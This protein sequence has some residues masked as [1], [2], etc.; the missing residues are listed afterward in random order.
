MATLGSLLVQNRIVGVTEIEKALQRQVIM[1]GDLATNLLELGS[2]DENTLTKYA[3]EAFGM[4]LLE[5]S[6]LES[7]DEKVVRMMPWEAVNEHKIAPIR[8][9]GNKMILAVSAPLPKDSLTDIGFLLGVEFSP[10]F[11]MEFRAAVLLNRCFGIPVPKRH[12]AVQKRLAPDAVLDL[13][14]LVPPPGRETKLMSAAGAEQKNVAQP[15]VPV[16]PD[17]V[18]TILKAAAPS[19]ASEA[20]TVS[21]SSATQAALFSSD[22]REPKTP[23]SIVSAALES[24]SPEPP[25]EDGAALPPLNLEAVKNKLLQAA[26]RDEILEV[27]MEAASSMFEY[28]LLFVIHGSEAAAHSTADK[29]GRIR[30]TSHPAVPLDMGGMFQTA[31]TTGS[32]YLGAPGK[33]SEDALILQEMGREHPKNCAILPVSLRG[34][35]ILLL[36]GDRGALGVKAASM[37][38][39]TQ[40]TRLTA[41]A[42][43]RLLLERKYGKQKAASFMPS[44]PG[45]SVF[46]LIPSRAEAEPAPPKVPMAEVSAPPQTAKPPAELVL[47]D[48]EGEQECDSEQ[49]DDAEQKCAPE[50]NDSTSDDDGKERL[51]EENQAESSNVVALTEERQH[52]VVLNM[53]AEIDRLVTRI[54]E[55]PKRFDQ[56]AL[57]VLLGMGDD[58]VKKLTAHFPGPLVCDRYQEIDRLPAVDR[59]GPL[60]KAL[61]AFGKTAIPHILALLE[62]RE[63]DVRFYAT[64]LFSK[65]KY[66]EALDGLTAR[67]FDND[68][69]IRG[70]AA[71]VVRGFAGHPEYRWTVKQVIDTLKSTSRDLDAKRIATS[72]LGSLGEPVGVEPLIEMLES[73][74]DRLV[75]A[76]RRALTQITFFD[77]GFSRKRWADWYNVYRNKTRIE[78]ALEG[79]ANEEDAVRRAAWIFLQPRVE[80]ADAAGSDAPSTYRDYKEVQDRLKRWWR[81]EGRDL[82]RI[83]TGN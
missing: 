23:V 38:D 68:R 62:S 75:R 39:L 66:P 6:L 77:L 33:T 70:I 83:T 53:E 44:N 21:P 36:Y 34:R 79:L 10:R 57:D 17:Y 28:C 20:A 63:T 13:P 72:I 25:D 51:E 81:E 41:E 8:L 5:R 1:G 32:F 19:R 31:F 50:Q 29:E 2:A 65:M 16:G 4:P 40:L 11:V 14:P 35:I 9:E 43:E 48:N 46:S 49:T 67:L 26:Q 15:T 73:V 42:F 55:S 37:S 7:F 18:D 59:H 64:F 56:A 69:H 71:D 52:S 45:F 78:W 27:F 76:S 74:D 80:D 3:A 82:H 47:D 60:L 54:L 24:L 30:K 12:I 58:A 61:I 22:T